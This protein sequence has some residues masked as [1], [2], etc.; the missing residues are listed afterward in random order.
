MQVSDSIGRYRLEK[1]LGVGAFGVVWLAHDDR[2]EA[3]VAVKVMADNWVWRIDLCERFLSEARLLR[4]AASPRVVQIYDIGELDDGRPYFVME[5]ADSGTLEDRLADGA[6]S[7]EDALR[8]AAEA[9]RAVAV[10]HGAG[11]LHRDIKPSNMLLASSPGGGIDRLLVADLGLAKSLANSSGLTMIAG[12]AGYMAPE[13]TDADEGV[14]ERADIYGLGALTYHLLTGAVPA[15]PGRI[16]APGRLREGVPGRADRVVLRAL[17]RDR[18]RRWPSATALAEELD[19]I[20]AQYLREVSAGPASGRRPGNGTTGRR[21]TGNRALGRHRP[22]PRRRIAL[23]AGAVAVAAGTL[24]GWMVL[25][26]Q[27]PS[28]VTASHSGEDYDRGDEG[29][30][31]NSPTGTVSSGPGGGMSAGPSVPAALTTSRGARR[32]PGAA[33]P[34]G[35][36]HGTTAAGP[37]D[38]GHGAVP[39]A[40]P[41]QQPSALQWT[42]KCVQ[43][44][45]WLLTG[46]AWSTNRTRMVMRTDGNLVI[47]DENARRRWS[48]GTSGSDYRAFFQGDGNLVVFDPD[49]VPQWHSGN[50]GHDGAILCLGADGSVNVLHN[51]QVVWSAGTAH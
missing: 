46:Q 35:A 2:L 37:G 50:Y 33:V 7:V 24:T 40:A 31:S 41:S 48:S 44:N 32:T 12:S 19:A 20:T 38:D 34:A 25:D 21:L 18:G 26:T 11:I 43:P 36:A 13:L 4:K 29:R 17:E 10:L 14:D 15:S 8:L 23:G 39:S 47:Y 28:D 16:I 30:P 6:P 27:E 22:T 5:Y 3:P 1:P 51:D 45:T 49:G 9:A 42:T